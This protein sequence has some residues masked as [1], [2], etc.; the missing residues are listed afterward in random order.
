[1]IFLIKAG[2][3]LTIFLILAIDLGV[4]HKKLHEI[5]AKEA[6]GWTVFWISVALLFMI[7]IYFGYEYHWAGLG[8]E[9]HHIQTGSDAALKYLTGYIVEYSLSLDNIFVIAMIFAYFKIPGIYQHRVLFWGILGALI[10][11]GIMIGAGT[12]LILKFSWMIYVFGVILIYTAIKMLRTAEDDAVE[13]EKNILFRIA[14][15]LYPVTD[16]LEG[17]KFFSKIGAKRAITPLFLVLLVIESTDVMFAVDSI[18]AIF[19]ITTDP[20]I[21]YTSNIFAILGLRSLYFALAALMNKFKYMKISIVFLL[22]YVGIKML[23]THAF[24]IPTV[25]SLCVIVTILSIGIAASLISDKRGIK[26]KVSGS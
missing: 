12:A 10:L 8:L 23:L 18:P 25:I 15:K 17:E 13:P 14:K 19:S 22:I 3:I 20:N 4:F 11:R 16:K 9:A 21:V 2:F 5:K 6:M 26:K 24:P 1:M 7:V